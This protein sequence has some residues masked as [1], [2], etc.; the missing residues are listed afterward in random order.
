M[1][2]KQTFKSERRSKIPKNLALITPFVIKWARE[3]S[4]YPLEVASKKI[5]VGPEKLKEWESGKSCPTMSQAKKMSQVYRRSLAIFYLPHPPKGLPLLKDFRTVE[6]KAPKYSPPLVFLMRQIQ[7]RQVWLSQYLREQGY[8]KLPFIGSIN[9]KSSVKI[10]TQSIINTIWEDER[11]YSK[12][13]DETRNTETL[14][15]H[16]INQ[17][18]R[19]GIFISRTSNLNSKNPIPVKEARGFVI[20]DPY[21]PFVFINSKDSYSARLFTLLHELAHL[22]LDVSGVPDHFP[23]NHKTKK[24]ST[25]FFCNQ[26]AAEILMPQKKIK[27]FSKVTNFTTQELKEFINT[28]C[29][30]FKVSSLA[31]LVRLKSLSLIK[32]QVFEILKKEYN[33]EYELYR[34]KQEQQLKKTKGGPPA[35]ML[36]IYANGESFTKIVFFSYKEGVLTGREA[37]NLLDMKLGNLEKAI[38]SKLIKTTGAI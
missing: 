30:I 18:E 28:H 6:G 7:E 14:L 31:L 13:L 4:H 9:V 20:S 35:N 10:A 33:K 17:C 2:T 11:Q 25:E 16:W 19:K 29:K 1:K 12:L 5:G 3:K 36:K 22:W 38:E 8:N 26:T 23:V 15:A 24:T 27:T 21:A 34:K 32:S 37:S